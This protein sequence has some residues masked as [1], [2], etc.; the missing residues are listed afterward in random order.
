MGHPARPTRAARPDVSAPTLRQVS[1]RR[2]T[3]AFL[4]C[5]AG[6][7]E[8]F[9]HGAAAVE[10]ARDAPEDASPGIVLGLDRVDHIEERDRRCRSSESIPAGPPDPS[11]DETRSPED[12]HH[13]GEDPFRDRHRRADPGDAEPWVRSG[14]RE[15]EHRPNGV[16]TLSRQFQSHERSITNSSERHRMYDRTGDHR[17]GAARYRSAPNSTRGHQH[18][19]VA[20]GRPAQQGPPVGSHRGAGRAR[21]QL[22]EVRPTAL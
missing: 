18:P 16:V 12:A 1:E 11:L 21:V 17:V 8:R 6:L 22:P 2:S 13:P 7:V 3:Q 5:D 14:G 15:R 4:E 9:V 20:S 19:Q 10:A